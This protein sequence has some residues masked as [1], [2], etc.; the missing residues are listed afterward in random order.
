MRFLC[1]ALLFLLVFVGG[2][3]I[4]GH[5]MDVVNEVG[6]HIRKDGGL[7]DSVFSL[8]ERLV[9]GENFTQAV[10]VWCEETFLGEEHTVEAVSAQDKLTLSEPFRTHLLPVLAYKN[11]PENQN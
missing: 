6:V 9:S 1:S 7:T 8:G 3:L 2:Q 4:P 10:K 11:A 5:M